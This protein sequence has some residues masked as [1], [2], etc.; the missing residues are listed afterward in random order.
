MNTRFLLV[1][2]L[3]FATSVTASAQDLTHHLTLGSGIEP[4]PFA[5]LEYGVTTTVFDRP[6]TLHGELTLP[7]FRL[8]GTSHRERIGAS[9]F[10]LP[11]S[12]WNANVRTS[13]WHHAGESIFARHNAIGVD[14][15]VRPGWY[16]SWGAIAADI[17]WE[18]TLAVRMDHLDR[19]TDDVSGVN[20]GWYTGGG[21]RFSFGLTGSYRI[22]SVTTSLRGG[23]RTTERLNP[24]VF[25]PFYARLDVA[26]QF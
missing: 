13:V 19:Y 25:F 3:F 4:T 24:T 23:I 2:A 12:A 1:F 6:S 22:G 11:S 21:G 8:D 14:L 17:G 26:Y 5:S 20:D 7:I 10:V 16:R 18:H 15:W 9:S